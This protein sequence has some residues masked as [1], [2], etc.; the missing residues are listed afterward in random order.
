LIGFAGAPWTVACYMVE[1]RG[2]KDYAYI[3]KW[4]Y[5]DP[6]GFGKLMDILIEATIDYLTRQVEAG[7]EVVQIFDTWA[8]VLADDLFD[9][10]AVA[11]TRRIVEGLRTR[12]PELPVIGFPKG[13]GANITRFVEETKVTAV[14]LDTGTPLAWARDVIQP[15]TIVQGNL[16]PMLLISGGKAME[17]R[18]REILDIL[19]PDRFIFN[20]GH[21]ITPAT[22]PEHV[23]KLAEIIQSEGKG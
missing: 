12:Y 23:T 9:K 18:I 8:G 11:P 14:S 21:G 10:W 5:G 4:A 1:G 15:K 17:A 2:S 3:K 16:D 7:A 22:P 19:G 6:V 13:V 20:L